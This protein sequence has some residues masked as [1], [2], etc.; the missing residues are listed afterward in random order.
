MCTDAARGR[1]HRSGEC[2]LPVD[3]THVFNSLN[4]VDLE[5][6]PAGKR[7]LPTKAPARFNYRRYSHLTLPCFPVVIASLEDSRPD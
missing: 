2:H 5:E 4:A 3:F 1:T 7:G 6:Y